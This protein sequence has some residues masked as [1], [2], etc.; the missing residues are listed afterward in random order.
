M[1]AYEVMINVNRSLIAGRELTPEEKR[2][3]VLRLLS[4]VSTGG[5]AERFY[6]GVRYPGNTDSVGRRM[7]PEFFIPPYNGGQKYRTVLGQMPKTHIFSANMYEL[8]ILRLLHLFS[9][10]DRAIGDMVSAALARLKTTCFA[11]E[12]DGVGECFDTNLVALRFI[13]TTVAGETM[14]MRERI[15]VYQN[16][17]GDQKR[18]WQSEWYFYLC[19]SELPFEVCKSHL[20]QNADLFKSYLLDRRGG[21]KNTDD[22]LRCC[23][24]SS[25]LSRIDDRTIPF[26]QFQ[27]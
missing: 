9:P 22:E 2:G 5:Q 20:E 7:Y 13:G 19:L 24:A 16:H 18:P 15:R 11:N 23:I 25:C 27:Q 10:G 14:W 4:A 6:V 26:K 17:R 8:E 12:D 1:T 3:A 21:V